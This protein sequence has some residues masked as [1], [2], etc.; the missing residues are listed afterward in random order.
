MGTP[1][2]KY[3]AAPIQKDRAHWDRFFG[4]TEEDEPDTA[5]EDPAIEFEILSITPDSG[6]HWIADVRNPETD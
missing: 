2:R 4:R 3:S 5:D 6:F 1:I